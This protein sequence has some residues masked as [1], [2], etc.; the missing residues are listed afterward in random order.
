MKYQ[1]IKQGSIWFAGSIGTGISV[2]IVIVLSLIFPVMI[3][4]GKIGEN[5]IS[6]VATV[7]Q[8]VSA[9]FGAWIAGK[10]AGDQKLLGIG[11]AVG[12]Y[13]LLL[14]CSAL[15][16]FDGFSPRIIIGL[17]SIL[18]GAGAAL[19]ILNKRKKRSKG[20]RSKIKNR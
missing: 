10:I 15:L 3:L 7:A 13:F 19:L 9:L 18:L 17:I 4:S 2:I 20:R 16:F 12:M 5:Q 8:F 14:I 1:R 6:L 11:L